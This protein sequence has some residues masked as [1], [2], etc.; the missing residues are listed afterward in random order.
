MYIIGA[1]GEDGVPGFALITRIMCCGIEPF[2]LAFSSRRTKRTPSLAVSAGVF[3]ANLVTARLV[4]VADY[5]GNVSGHATRKDLDTRIRWEPGPVTGAP[6][7]VDSPWVYECTLAGTADA[8]GSTLFFG[9]VRNILVSEELADS[10][11]G[12]VAAAILD[13]AIYVP[14]QYFGLGRSILGVGESLSQFGPRNVD[15]R[16]GR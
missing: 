2:T 10:T 1:S 6:V 9:E 3:T 5:F 7:L 4:S 16:A 12:K 14:P 15:G 8:A 13:P 11:S